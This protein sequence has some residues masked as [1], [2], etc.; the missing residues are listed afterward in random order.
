MSEKRFIRVSAKENHIINSEDDTFFLETKED[1]DKVVALLN[2]LSDENGQLKQE[3][4][5]YWKCRDKWKQEA[6]ELKKDNEQL[7]QTI[8]EMKSDERL[9]A[10]EIVKLNKEV[11]DNQFL[12]LG[13]DY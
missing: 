10:N 7:R 4:K 5:Q 11:K 6:K 1:V 13:N 12:R 2:Q 8:K 9:Y 3:I